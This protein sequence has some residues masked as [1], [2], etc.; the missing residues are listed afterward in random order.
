MLKN[1]E[2]RNMSIA[3]RKTGEPMKGLTKTGSPWTMWTITDENAIR[4]NIFMHGERVPPF[5]LGARYDVDYEVSEKGNK[6]TLGSTKP[7]SMKNPEIEEI[8]KIVTEIRDLLLVHKEK[9]F[10]TD[11]SDTE[12]EFPDIPAEFR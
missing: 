4:Y 8:K 7:I 5:Q 11:K 12:V 6:I 3:I 1:I 9:S 2:I 10:L